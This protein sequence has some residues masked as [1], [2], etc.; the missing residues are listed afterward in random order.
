[1]KFKTAK[2]QRI[3]QLKPERKGKILCIAEF[4]SCKLAKQRAESK[5]RPGTTG[6]AK[7]NRLKMS[8]KRA[9]FFP[10]PKI[11]LNSG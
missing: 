4:F 10:N 1:M 6:R 9:R 11:D 8:K 7:S 3:S 2:K 5:K